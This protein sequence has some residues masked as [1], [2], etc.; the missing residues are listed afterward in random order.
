[1]QLQN[2]SVHSTNPAK[3]GLDSNGQGSREYFNSS[4]NTAE[5]KCNSGVNSNRMGAINRFLQSQL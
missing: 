4:T 5:S 3:I 2:Q 1:M